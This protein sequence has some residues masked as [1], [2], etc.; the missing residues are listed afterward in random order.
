MT[1]FY[2]YVAFFFVLFFVFV[3]VCVGCE[4]E[5]MMNAKQI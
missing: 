3:C 1:D 5:C 2:V 4:I